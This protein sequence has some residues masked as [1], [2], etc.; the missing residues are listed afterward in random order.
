[1]E[2]VFEWHPRKAK[3]N[4]AKHGVSF[5]EA[6]RVFFDSLAKI[7][8]D[9][10]HSESEGREVIVGHS[11]LGRLLVVCFVEREPVARIISARQVTTRERYDYEESF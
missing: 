3:S 11:K 9:P 4:L 7:F 8:A 2:L 10:D 1:M 6:T 5:E